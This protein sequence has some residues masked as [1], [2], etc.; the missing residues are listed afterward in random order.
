MTEFFTRVKN[1]NNSSY[2]VALNYVKLFIE[3]VKTQPDFS[4]IEK[5]NI[6]YSLSIFKESLNYWKSK[7]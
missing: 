3:D 6:L 4:E 7:L 1:P 2:E 5:T